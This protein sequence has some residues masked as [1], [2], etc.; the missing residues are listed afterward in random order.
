VSDPW[1]DF[2]L[3]WRSADLDTRDGIDL[4]LEEVADLVEE[5]DEELD[6]KPRKF[7]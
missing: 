2:L 7:A 1:N 5:H 3:I 4:F 6:F